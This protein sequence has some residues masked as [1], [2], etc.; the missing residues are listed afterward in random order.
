MLRDKCWANWNSCLFP[1]SHL[2]FHCTL[3]LTEFHRPL[4][5]HSGCLQPR[6]SDLAAVRGKELCFQIHTSVVLTFSVKYFPPCWCSNPPFLQI[7]MLPAIFTYLQ[8]RRRKNFTN[9][10]FKSFFWGQGLQYPAPNILL[11]MPWMERAPGNTAWP[12]PVS[13]LPSLQTFQCNE[14]KR[15]FSLNVHNTYLHLDM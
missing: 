13:A 10:S 14:G 1:N 15:P 11:A 12:R 8:C 3:L 5:F 7:W 9:P 4:L 2:Y 6:W